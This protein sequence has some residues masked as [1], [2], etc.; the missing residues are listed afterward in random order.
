[1]SDLWRGPDLCQSSPVLHYWRLG[2][3]LSDTRLL[4]LLYSPPRLVPHLQSWK[5]IEITHAWL[6]P[7]GFEHLMLQRKEEKLWVPDNK[8]PD[9]TLIFAK[10][11]S[12]V[13][14]SSAEGTSFSSFS[15][16]RLAISPTSGMWTTSLPPPPSLLMVKPL[17]L[18]I[19]SRPHLNFT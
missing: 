8:I 14:I 7:L 9:F 13:R 1:M 6:V 3:D 12:I 10:W 4:D 16:P 5:H 11:N 18:F 19:P 15:R 17:I 2:S